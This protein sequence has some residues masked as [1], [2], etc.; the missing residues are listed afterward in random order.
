MND[1]PI[2]WVVALDGKQII[3]A[4]HGCGQDGQPVNCHLDEQNNWHCP[5]C[6]EIYGAAFPLEGWQKL[7]DA[8]N[9]G[10][11]KVDQ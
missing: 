10:P 11:P 5:R 7:T 9:A 3:A 6:Y 4:Q 1:K 8:I 2:P